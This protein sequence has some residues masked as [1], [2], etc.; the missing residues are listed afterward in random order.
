MRHFTQKILFFLIIV[1]CYIT[2]VF[3]YNYYNE[4]HPKIKKH[5]ITFIGDSHTRYSLIPDSFFSSVNYGLNGDPIAVQKWKIETLCENDQ[6][7]T[8]IISLGYHNFGENL[9][10]LFKRKDGL[11]EKL[12][13][14]YLFIQPKLLFENELKPTILIKGIANK[15]KKP[16]TDLSYL[17]VFVKI[18]NS[19]DGNDGWRINEHF[20]YRNTRVNHIIEEIEEIIDF[21]ESKKIICFFHLPPVT[22]EYKKRIPKDVISPTD[23]FLNVLNQRGLFLTTIE[24]LPD[25][26][27]FDPDHLNYD[28]AKI[29]THS[30][31][32][33]LYNKDKCTE[34]K[35]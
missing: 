32:Q 25:S 12:L 15:L 34:T 28:G 31:K 7:D 4:N 3:V 33:A 21:C 30:L 16:S 24:T 20:K 13:N 18:Q 22:I 27:F 10:A 17:G 26:C 1:L 6:I 29:Y 35:R 5:N 9:S 23:S 14:R 19:W 11:S 2:L 8:V